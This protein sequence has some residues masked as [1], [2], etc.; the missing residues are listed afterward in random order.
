M[1]GGQG[2][3]DDIRRQIAVAAMMVPA[4]RAPSVTPASST[5]SKEPPPSATPRD[6]GP[7]SGNDPILCSHCGRTARNGLTCQGMCV[8]DSD[9]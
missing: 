6:A 4:A 8:A 7:D 2:E 3:R 1:L 9:Y 5:A